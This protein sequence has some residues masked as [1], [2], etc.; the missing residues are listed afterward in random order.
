MILRGFRNILLPVFMLGLLLLPA[1]CDQPRPQNTAGRVQDENNL[2]FEIVPSAFELEDVPG[3]DGTYQ[4]I[5]MNGWS[6]TSRPG[7]PELPMKGLLIQVPE[8]GDVDLEILDQEFASLPGCRIVPVPELVRPGEGTGGPRFAR[9][10]TIY[11]STSYFPGPLAELGS[12]AVI[13]GVPVIRVMVYP[14]QWNPATGELLYATKLR[15]RVNLEDPLPPDDSGTTAGADPGGAGHMGAFDAILKDIV[16]NYQVRVKEA[17]LSERVNSDRTLF[18]DPG[19]KIRITTDGIYRVTYEDLAG[20]GLIPTDPETIQLFNQ[21]SEVAINVVS[22]IPFG[23][24]DYIEFY[25]QGIESPYTDANVY[26][27]FEGTGSG[28]RTSELDGEVTGSGTLVESF[29]E[30]LHVEEN[31]EMWDTTPGAPDEDYWFWARVYAPDTRIYNLDIPSPAPGPSGDAL[32][33][34]VFRGRST[35][36]PHPNHHTLVSLNGTGIGDEYWDGTVEHEQEMTV[37]ASLLVDGTNTLTVESP[38]DTGAVVDIIYH[39]RLE[40]EYWRFFTAREDRLSFS[41]TGEQRVKVEIDGL[42][43]P[44][45][46][47]YDVTDPYEAMEVVNV[48]VQ[49][50]GPDYTAAFEDVLSG[51]KTFIVSTVDEVMQPDSMERMDPVDLK[52][53]ANGA[54]YLLITAEEFLSSVTPLIDLRTDQGLRALAVSVEDIYND[55]NH[56]IVDPAAIRGFLQYAYENWTPPAPTYVLLVGDANIDYK[57]YKGTGKQSRIPVHLSITPV[58]GLTPDDNWYVCLEGEDNYPEMFVG[59]MPAG[60][61]EDAEDVVAKICLYENAQGDLPPDVLLVADDNEPGFETLSDD[62]VKYLPG[63]FS[64]DRVYLRLY[65]EVEDATQDILSGLDQ[66]RVIATYVGHGAVTN[67]AGEFVFESP[68]VALLENGDNLPFVITL[69]CLNGYFSQPSYYC[70][71]EELVAPP[72]KGAIGCFSPSG[73]GY[74]WEHNLLGN[75]LFKRIFKQGERIL[76]SLTTGSKI[77]ARGQGATEDMLAM[78]TL[79]GPPALGLKVGPTP[80]SNPGARAAILHLLLTPDD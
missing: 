77:A 72:D 1:D 4:R 33:R 59:R 40:V 52:N 43:Q 28:E 56:G 62:L 54:D 38:G 36:S 79:I 17:P 8:T 24:G 29:L 51:T 26:W 19:V 57:D 63:R 20:V 64:A 76:G 44:D 53:T 75:E 31:H 2:T 61:A 14:F 46:M 6:K 15:L 73:L 32:V 42:S 5:R 74:L 23:P 60:S 45:L 49:V 65:N 18:A 30:T 35:A 21:G 10:E 25:G 37:S 47:I 80:G 9:D 58:L 34:V 69:D 50:N 48:S 22:G 68:D 7:C 41:V 39:N 70:L 16:I 66:G 11:R 12:R 55:F 13:R 3:P 71:A 67:W 78:F 27:L